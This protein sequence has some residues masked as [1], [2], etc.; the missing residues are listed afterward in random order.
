MNPM[1]VG[2][3]R[4]AFFE[5][6]ADRIA[7]DLHKFLGTL[8]GGEA[9]LGYGFNYQGPEYNGTRQIAAATH[10]MVI[11]YS[12]GRLQGGQPRLPAARSMDDLAAVWVAAMI[13]AE[14]SFI[15]HRGHRWPRIA[16]GNTEVEIISALLRLTGT[17][18]VSSDPRPG[19]KRCWFWTV[20]QPYDS[21]NLLVQLL[22]H[23]L[24]AQRWVDEH[25]AMGLVSG[26]EMPPIRTK[27]AQ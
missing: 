7:D 13:D 14:G 21:L 25:P 4:F 20:D 1:P 18:A 23:S 24:K 6:E 9:I 2:K 19:H 22:P 27:D 11:L 10:G 12:A 15:E 3:V 8:Q 26:H 17:G 5:G 16:V